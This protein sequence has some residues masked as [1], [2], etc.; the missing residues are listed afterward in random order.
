MAEA[1][2]MKEE[3]KQKEDYEN[4]V[5]TP[6]HVDQVIDKVAFSHF[7]GT[8]MTACCIT[9]KNGFSV[10]GQSNCLHMKDFDKKKGEEAAFQNGANKIYELE[11]Y[12]IRQVLSFEQQPQH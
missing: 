7:K 9:L 4:P 10:L 1:I 3:D 12:L 11:G 2:D 8:T 5:V 6:K